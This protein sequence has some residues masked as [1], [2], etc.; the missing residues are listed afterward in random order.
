MNSKNAVATLLL[1]ALIASLQVADSS[2]VCPQRIQHHFNDPVKVEAFF[3]ALR[4]LES[5]GNVCKIGENGIGPYQVSKQYYD[6][7]VNYDQQLKSG[8]SYT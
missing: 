6:Q 2:P 8:G 4:K 7:A 1:L 5:D 3:N